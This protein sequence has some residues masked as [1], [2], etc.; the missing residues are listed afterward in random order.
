M[1]IAIVILGV[2][3][4]LSTW[5]CIAQFR[6]CENLTS[7]A[8]NVVENMQKISGII[9]HSNTVLDNPVLKAAFAN[10]DETGTFFQGI[11]EIQD[12]LH[13]HN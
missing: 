6:R 10:D 4:V 8:N 9:E 5:V 2:Y 13:Y 12:L 3:A 11:Q 7:I 1:V